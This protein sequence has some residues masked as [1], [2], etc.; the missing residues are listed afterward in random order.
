MLVISLSGKIS[1]I[2]TKNM[3]ETMSGVWHT[4]KLRENQLYDYRT[5]GELL[6]TRPFHHEPTLQ[7]NLRFSV[8]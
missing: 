7:V 6:K 1:I 4:R 3:D 5:K 8:T 2:G